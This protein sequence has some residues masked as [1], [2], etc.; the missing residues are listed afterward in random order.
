MT[1]TPGF[2]AWLALA[3][4]WTATEQVIVSPDGTFLAARSEDRMAVWDVAKGDVRLV[5]ETV[6]TAVAD[7]AVRRIKER[8]GTCPEFRSASGRIRDKT[9]KFIA[10]G[11]V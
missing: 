11:K 6:G 1:G 3:E 5:L 8:E 10:E 4:D 7:W 2:N 9:R